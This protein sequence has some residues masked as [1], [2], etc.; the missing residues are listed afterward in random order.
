MGKLK[1]ESMELGWVATNVYVVSNTESGECLI[2]D[3][4]AKAEK[5]IA[6]IEEGGYQPR[7]I[8]L[9]HGHAD[10]ILAV[11]EL[12]DRYGIPVYMSEDEK[13]LIADAEHNGAMMLFR[14]NI[15]TH[16][17]IFLQDGQELELLGC[18]FRVLATPGHTRGSLCYYEAEEKLLFT[19]DTLF[20]NSYGRYDLYSGNG[21]A[22]R[23][24]ILNKLFVLEDEVRAFPGHMAPTTIGYEKKY[25]PILKGI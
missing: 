4:A 8:L 14:K 18:R 23:E 25:N 22:L 10:H 17:D 24:S 6:C 16:G 1:I 21:T 11:D 5:I 15:T 13:E 9:T 20:K 12:R 2:I 7:A 3:P 19:G